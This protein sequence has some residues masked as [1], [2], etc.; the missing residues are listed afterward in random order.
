MKYID[1]SI[2]NIQTQITFNWW[3]SSIIKIIGLIYWKN[4]SI[5]IYGICKYVKSFFSLNFF[6]LWLFSEQFSILSFYG[7]CI[8][9]MIIF[10]QYY[11]LR[12]FFF[13]GTLKYFIPVFIITQK[14][15]ILELNL[16][17]LYFLVCNT[18]ISKY[19]FYYRIKI[20]NLY[21]IYNI[22]LYKIYL[23]YF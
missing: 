18:N 22:K 12:E 3:I 7:T 15:T 4:I 19:F 23:K 10:T 6:F 16:I 13:S 20:I 1:W 2:L 17:S 14:L 21:S 8:N 9:F 5:I 11:L